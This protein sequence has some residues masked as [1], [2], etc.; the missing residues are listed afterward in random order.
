MAGVTSFVVKNALIGG[1]AVVDHG[2]IS[3]M[4][5]GFLF[6]NLRAVARSQ[7]KR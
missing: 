1:S 2:L 5:I 6:G 4:Q 3:F 7:T